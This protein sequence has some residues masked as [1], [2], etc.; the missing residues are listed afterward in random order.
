MK[1]GTG[2]AVTHLTIGDA[3][4]KALYSYKNTLDDGT[5]AINAVGTGTFS[6]LLTANGGQTFSGGDLLLNRQDQ[7]EAY[8]TRPDVTGYKQIAFAVSGGSNL[9]MI[10][11]H[12]NSNHFRGPITA[13]NNVT[14]AGNFGV[15]TIVAS[16]I[17]QETTSTTLA[18][19]VAF[20]PTSDGIYMITGSAYGAYL[21][22]EIDWT[23]VHTGST[24]TYVPSNWT[25]QNNPTPLT[26]YAI[27]NKGG[28]TITVKYKTTNASYPTVASMAIVAM[29]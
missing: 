11:F 21:Y 23:D 20:T 16:A 8:I 29:T 9:D 7:T 28:N 13:V 10:D 1:V 6:G 22:I 2:T 15:G 26:P 3:N 24:Y 14:T 25:A 19:L 12:S 4:M 27:A 17:N 18:I 5:G